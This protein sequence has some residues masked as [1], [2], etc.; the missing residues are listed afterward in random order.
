MIP[1]R[2]VRG[3]LLSLD[4]DML[5]MPQWS[6]A[7]GMTFDAVGFFGNRRS[8]RYSALVEDGVVQKIFIEEDVTQVKA[9]SADNL[10]QSM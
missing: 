1:A 3:A 10:L 8:N 2:Y 6:A 5:T 4:L 7:A 9:S